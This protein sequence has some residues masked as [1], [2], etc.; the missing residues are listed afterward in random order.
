MLTVL[1]VLTVSQVCTHAK[2]YNVYAL[3][4][5]SSLYISYSSIKLSYKSERKEGREG[6]RKR[7]KG[8][9]EKKKEGRKERIIKALKRV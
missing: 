4:M 2:A 5:C 7:G 6:T 8:R 9:Q 1:T 3:S